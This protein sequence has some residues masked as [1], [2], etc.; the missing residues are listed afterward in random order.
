MKNIQ[1]ISRDTSA[2]VA[3]MRKTGIH[4]VRLLKAA[5]DYYEKRLTPEHIR[6]LYNECI[7]E[8]VLPVFFE[9]FCIEVLA[10]RTRLNPLGRE[11]YERHV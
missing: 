3:L 6:R 4:P 2:L 1:W 11:L 9:S 8:E 5:C 7:V 10:N